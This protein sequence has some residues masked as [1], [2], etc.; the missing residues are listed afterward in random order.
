MSRLQHSCYSSLP[1]RCLRC[2]YLL[3]VPRGSGA[4]RPLGRVCRR[5]LGRRGGRPAPPPCGQPRLGAVGDSPRRLLPLRLGLTAPRAGG[6]G[7]S[8]PLRS[9]GGPG[10]GPAPPGTRFKPA[11]GNRRR[12]GRREAA[13]RPRRRGTTVPGPS[14]PLPAAAAAMGWEEKQVRGYPEFVQTAQRYHGR[15]IFALFCGD[16]DAAGR[17]WCPDCVTGE[18][19][20]T[21]P[22]A[23]E[24]ALLPAP[25]RGG[26]GGPGHPAP[27]GPAG[28]P[29]PR[30]RAAAF[31]L[32]GGSLRGPGALPGTPGCSPGAERPHS[33]PPPVPGIAGDRVLAAAPA[34]AALGLPAAFTERHVAQGKQSDVDLRIG[35]FASA[36]CVKRQK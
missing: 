36:L 25:W 20:G 11:P 13:R 22:P 1:R 16:K 24:S 12:R 21:P 5:A 23:A 29:C 2:L 26:L 19:R 28:R 7:T 15:P 31:P 34:R 4:G 27:L 33:I 10:P 17:S 3:R 35:P 30:V 9:G 6:T 18:C 14:P 32:A 8:G